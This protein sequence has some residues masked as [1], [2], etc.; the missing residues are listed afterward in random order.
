MISQNAHRR[1]LSPEWKDKFLAGLI[2]ENRDTSN[3]AIAA[4]AKKV[5]VKVDKNKIAKKRYEMIATGETAPVEKTI[6]KDGKARKQLAQKARKTSMRPRTS[7]STPGVLPASDPKPTPVIASW[8]DQD[9][10]AIAE[11]MAAHMTRDQIGHLFAL[12]MD[13]VKVKQAS[14]AKSEQMTTHR[15]G[16]TMTQAKNLEA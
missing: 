1:H 9:P 12:A 16:S 11:Q 6:G 4:E 3:R 14:V 10:R 8:W 13:A 5:G 2:N 15:K 7:M